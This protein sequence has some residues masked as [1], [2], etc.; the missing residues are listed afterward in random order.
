MRAAA[1]HHDALDG[2]TCPHKGEAV[3]GVPAETPA[4]A[5]PRPHEPEGIWTIYN[6]KP[7]RPN[8]TIG[9]VYIKNLKISK[10]KTTRMTKRK[11]M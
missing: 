8:R 6:K 1:A 5:S 10:T 9:R 7:L 4:Q 3:V 11:K 2:E